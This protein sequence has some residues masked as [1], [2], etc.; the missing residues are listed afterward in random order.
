MGE[1]EAA[2][3]LA[4]VVVVGRSFDGLGASNPVPPALLGKPVVVGP[5]HHNF[6]EMVEA[7]VR[8]GAAVVS[9]DPWPDIRRILDDRDLRERMAA[10][11]PETVAAHAGAVGRN[12]EVIRTQLRGFAPGPDV[13]P[14]AP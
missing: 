14:F 1:A 5:D 12:V 8:G 2:T 9:S 13:V 4:D 11:G 10:A 3:A 7:L 6:R